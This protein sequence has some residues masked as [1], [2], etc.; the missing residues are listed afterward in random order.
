MS[1]FHAVAEHVNWVLA[2]AAPTG[3]A[4][5]GGAT[6]GTTSGA[7]IANA[8]R[9]FIAPF[10]LLAI[11][12]AAMSFLFKRQMTEFLQFIA[13]GAGVAVFFYVPG[14][15]EKIANTIAAVF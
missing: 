4:T 9:D 1:M 13:L 10:F 5:T 3:G 8:I 14:V 11:G 2:Q 6:G 15:V 7:N 12:I